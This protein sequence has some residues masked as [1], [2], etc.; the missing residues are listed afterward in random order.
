MC[1]CERHWNRLAI[2]T[3][4]CLD[5]V[6]EV[7]TTSERWR[8][9]AM[10]LLNHRVD[11]THEIEYETRCLACKKIFGVNESFVEHVS[12]EVDKIIGNC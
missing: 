8:K 12:R 5:H 3:C 9:I 11:V 7:K 4:D 1:G 6:N 10:V 2:C